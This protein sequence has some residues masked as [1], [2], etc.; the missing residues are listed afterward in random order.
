V[1]SNPR[2][3]VDALYGPLLLWAIQQWQKPGHSLHLALDTT[4]LW[5]RFCV[6]VISVVCHGR[7]IPLLWRTLEHPS[8]SVSAPVVIGL[9]QRADRLLTGFG[10]ITVLADRGFPSC[11]QLF[12]DQKSGGFQLERSGLRD[13]E[14]ID[15]LLLVVAIAVLLS[16][17]QGYAVSLSGQRRRVDPH[18]KRGLSF[19]RIGLH[20][21]QQSVITASRALL[22]W[23]PI[24]LQTLE[25]CIPSRG[26]R[27][28]QKQPWFTKVELPPLSPPTALTAI[29]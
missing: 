18:W 8:A 6:V 2:I 23:L 21:L 16:S 3:E 12:R 17:L 15:Q 27:R 22:A 24:P 5:N 20:W 11:E 7:A 1:L 28:R 13:P 10:A 4:V 9:L 29:A 19:A 25:L 26:V 14:R